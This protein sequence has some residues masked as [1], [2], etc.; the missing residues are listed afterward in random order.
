[1]SKPDFIDYV[2]RPFCMFFREDEKEEMACRGAAVAERLA[3]KAV[4]DPGHA[5]LLP[6]D[7]DAWT[8]AA[9]D[10]LLFE[11]VCLAC[12]FRE[13]DCEWRSDDPPHDA[14]PCG[15]LILLALL[16]SRGVIGEAIPEE[17]R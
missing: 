14:E 12:E 11:H 10:A 5:G 17:C 2:C 1:M 15:G 9:R 3:G 4:F 6:K 7:A 16:M 13:E 8:D